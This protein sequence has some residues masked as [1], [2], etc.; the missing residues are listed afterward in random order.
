MEFVN[1]W[2]VSEW[3]FGMLKRGI[4]GISPNCFSAILD[5]VGFWKPYLLDDEQLYWIRCNGVVAL[6][7]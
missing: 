6:I 5:L 7:Y 3:Y 2:I 4:C 1:S